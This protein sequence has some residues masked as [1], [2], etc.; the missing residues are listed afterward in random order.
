M[1]LSTKYS[2]NYCAL[3]KA[4]GYAAGHTKFRLTVQRA[5]GCCPI[6]TQ[7]GGQLFPCF[8]KRLFCCGIT[9]LCSMDIYS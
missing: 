2:S 6:G 8:S 4:S 9:T 7:S 5:Q 1:F 3:T